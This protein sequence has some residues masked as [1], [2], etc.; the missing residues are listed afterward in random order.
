VRGKGKDADG[1]EVSGEAT[2]RFLVYRDDTELMRQAADHDFLTK[3]AAAGGGK[4]HRAEDLAKFL[5]ELADR[6]AADGRA[7]PTYYPDWKRK[8][9]GALRPLVLLA[10]VGLLGIEWGL[11]RYWGMV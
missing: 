4:F 2:A 6:P 10:F 3:L 5:R 9:T 8:E 11:R 7:K 1:S